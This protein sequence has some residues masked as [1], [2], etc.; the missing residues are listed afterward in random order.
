MLNLYLV[1]NAS[2]QFRK[3]LFNLHRRLLDSRTWPVIRPSS[4]IDILI[5]HFIRLLLKPFLDSCSRSVDRIMRNLEQFTG[6]C[7]PLNIDMIRTNWCPSSRAFQLAIHF[8]NQSFHPLMVFLYSF[9]LMI[10]AFLER[11]TI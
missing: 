3:V 6:E 11:A 2:H 4:M 10:S 8:F 7:L 9:P 5:V 1:H